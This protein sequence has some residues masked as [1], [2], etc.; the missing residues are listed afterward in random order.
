MSITAKLQTIEVEKEKHVK[1]VT[2]LQLELHVREEEVNKL[3]RKS[4]AAATDSTSV[5]IEEYE[6]EFIQLF[7][8]MDSAS[9]IKLELIEA[10]RKKARKLAEHALV[11][12][13]VERLK[14]K[15]VSLP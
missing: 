4:A 5:L 9:R 8:L 13:E 14:S 11:K 6:E 7:R 10:E 3:Q 15:Q 1:E 2:R 12:N